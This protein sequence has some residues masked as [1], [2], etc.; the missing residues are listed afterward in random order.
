[1]QAEQTFFYY[2]S[3]PLILSLYNWLFNITLPE[4]RKN[5]YLLNF[6]LISVENKVYSPPN[7]DFKPGILPLDKSLDTHII[8]FNRRYEIENNCVKERCELILKEKRINKEDYKEF[9]QSAQ[10]IRKKLDKHRIFFEK[11]ETDEK[12]ERLESIV[13]ENS[14]D[15][16]AILNLSKHYL[17]VGKYE[18]AKEL[19][20]KAMNLE[21]KNGEIHYFMGIAFGYI[22]QYE[23]TREKIEMAKELGYKP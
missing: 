14:E 8:S 13:R 3:Y 23:K 2:E 21:P 9:Y 5:D 12:G 15:V 17:A 19:L 18:S 10:E 11:P 4:N 7:K 1:M 16:T 22:G 6:R 20:E